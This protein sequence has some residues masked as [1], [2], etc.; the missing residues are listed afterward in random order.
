MKTILLLVALA[1]A[2]CATEGPPVRITLVDDQVLVGHLTTRTIELETGMGPLEFDSA[3]A[4]E[5]GPIEGPGIDA[6]GHMV[7]LW[8]RNGSEFRGRWNRPEVEV[9]LDVGGEGHSID[10][11]IA[12]LARL[13][14]SGDEIWPEESVFRIRTKD[15]DDFF[16]DVSRTQLEFSNELGT[17]KPYLEEIERIDP[18]DEAKRSWRMT[19]ENGTSLVAELR[20]TELDL[21]FAMGP[22]ALRLPL[23][24]V[25]S[26]QRERFSVPSGG[27]FDELEM[28]SQSAGS[29]PAQPEDGRFYSNTR[30]K[31]AKSAPT[32]E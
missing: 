6:S 3:D 25:V 16:V 2:G 32:Q 30:Q 9:Q 18:L 15:G 20:Q 17:F 10:V 14:F 19:L 1:A 13:Q 28:S 5:L 23:A 7:N 11:P 27:F 24:A 12:K 29:A 26:M 4:G 8:L 22:E 21:A 31:A